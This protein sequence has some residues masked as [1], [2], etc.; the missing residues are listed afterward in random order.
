MF[1]SATSK[2]IACLITYPHEV[3]RS[4]M[5]DTRCLSKPG[6]KNLLTMTREILENEGFRAFYKGM[7]VR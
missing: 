1:A 2:V 6:G 5:M 4:R 3:I 7:H